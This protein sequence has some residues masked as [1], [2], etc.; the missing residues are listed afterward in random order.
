MVLESQLS[1]ISQLV[2]SQLSANFTDSS[3]FSSMRSKSGA[4][5]V[6]IK[7]LSK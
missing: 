7:I 5:Q 4:L 1:P 6:K 3:L 2:F